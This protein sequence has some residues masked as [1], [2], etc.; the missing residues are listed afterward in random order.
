MEFFGREKEIRELR[1]VR[2]AARKSA[3]L[4]VVT[5]RRRVGKTELLKRAFGDGKTPCLYLL[6]TRKT[7]RVQAEAFQQ[8]TEKVLGIRIRGRCERFRD[9]F[10][11]IMAASTS[12]TFTVVID[13]F[14]EFDRVNAG[15]FGDVQGVWDEFHMRSKINLVACGSVNRLMNKIFFNDAEPLYGRNT[16]KLHLDPFKVSLLKRI[17]RHYKPDY[18]QEDLLTLWTLTGGIARYVDLLMSNEAFT[19]DDMLATVFGRITS[20]ID[21]GKTVLVE[22]FGKDYGTYFTIL[23]SIASGR[24]TFAEIKNELGL[25]VGGYLTKLEDD[26]SLI[27]KKQPLFEKTS[28]KNCH[29]QID[30]CFFRFW[31]RFVYKYQYLIELRRFEE[32]TAV[33]KRDLGVFCGYSLERYFYWKFIEDTSFTRM[34]GWWDRKGENEIDLVCDD[35]FAGKLVFHEVKID[36]RRIDLR[37]LKEKAKA[38]IEKNPELNGRSLAFRALSL[39]DM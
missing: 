8:E 10:E 9:V 30:D 26:Y 6:V 5:G 19:A 16:G 32:L 11:E 36:P 7:E 12:R 21:E 34:G 28:N 39:K 27:S 37:R 15:I 24:T 4:T 17:F 29:Y 23:A 22:E 3:R 14:Q 33:V 2:D 25:E 1:K 38:F 20:F 31:F 13:E 18:R 35:E